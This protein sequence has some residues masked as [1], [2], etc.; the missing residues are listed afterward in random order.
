M[1]RLY[2]WQS[3][4]A[5]AAALAVPGVMPAQERATFKLLDHPVNCLAVSPDGKLVALAYSAADSTCEVRALPS[6][7]VVKTRKG[8]TRMVR[9]LAFSPDGKLLATAGVDG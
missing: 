8:H 3:F 2:V 5:V 7:E 1:N 6:G 9:G 4:V